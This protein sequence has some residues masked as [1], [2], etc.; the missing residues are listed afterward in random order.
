MWSIST[1]TQI[2]VPIQ[3]KFNFGAGAGEEKDTLVLVH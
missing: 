3:K 2:F 1:T